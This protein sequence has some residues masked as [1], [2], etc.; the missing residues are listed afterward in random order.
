MV[1]AIPFSM[2]VRE[3]GQYRL[4]ASRVRRIVIKVLSGELKNARDMTFVAIPKM[5]LRRSLSSTVNT[6]T[7]ANAIGKNKKVT[8]NTHTN[9][10]DHIR[11]P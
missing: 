2:I 6:R 3:V 11:Q 4:E 9:K 10:P 5:K 1:Q 8:C 7:V